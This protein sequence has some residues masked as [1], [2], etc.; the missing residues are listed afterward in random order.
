L[1]GFTQRLDVLGTVPCNGFL[2]AIAQQFD[3]LFMTACLDENNIILIDSG[4]LRNVFGNSACLRGRKP[5]DFF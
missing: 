2:T 3:D 4:A 5:V 1:Q